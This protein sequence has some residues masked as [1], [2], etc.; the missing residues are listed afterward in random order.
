[1]ENNPLDIETQISPYDI[2]TIIIPGNDDDLESPLWPVGARLDDRYP[3][4]EIRGG[5]GKSGM[6]IVYIVSDED[7]LYAVKTFQR[8]FSQRLPFIQRFIQEARTW[9]LLGFH[10][11]IIQALRLDIIHAIP[12]LFMEYVP[13][14]REGRYSTAD[15]LRHGPMPLAAALRF[16]VQFCAGMLHAVQ[17]APGLVH[18][19]I[20]PENLL[21]TPEG[22]LKISDFGLAHCKAEAMSYRKTAEIMAPGLT[23]DSRLTQAGTIFGTPE[24]MAPEQFDDAADVTTAADIYAFA[25]CLCEWLTGKPPFEARST[26]ALGRIAEFRR[27]HAE[28]PPVRLRDK[29]PDCPKKLDELVFECLAKDPDAR[30]RDFQ[31]LRERLLHIAGGVL[32]APIKPPEPIAPTP[33]DVA[34]QSRSLSLLDGYAQAIRMRNL[35]EGQESS[36]YAFHLALASYFHC[37]Q[38]SIEERLQ[39]EKASRARTSESGYEAVRRLGELLLGQ[40]DLAAANALISGYL[41]REPQGLDRVLEAYVRLLCAQEKYAEAIAH[42][43]NMGDSLRIKILRAYVLQSSRKHHDFA[44]AL[45]Q[46][47]LEILERLAAKIAALSPTD[48]VGWAQDGDADA[49]QAVFSMLRPEFDTTILDVVDGAIWPDLNAYPDFAPDMAW[50]SHALGELAVLEEEAPAAERQMFLDAAHLLDYPKRLELQM[51]RDEYWFWMQEAAE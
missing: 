47:I 15:Y 4:L 3:V 41:A 49:L 32:T 39:L 20:K 26:S 27:K 14:D 7:R 24:Y 29:Y 1:M 28:E 21:V 51:E 12:Y 38:D 30:V 42:L 10:E 45:R 5:H 6:G 9:M 18:R 33:S 46:L 11:N 22:V 43:E 35:R 48:C 17:A 44:L 13:R 25:C 16:A 23:N 37:H 36:P 19:D 8:R 31:T 34:M 50:L 2:P 40:G